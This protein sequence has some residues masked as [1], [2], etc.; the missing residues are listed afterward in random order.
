MIYG[1]K[2]GLRA[3]TA[4]DT[5]VLHAELYD[6]VPTQARSDT[7]PWRPL[8]ADSEHGP[9]AVRAPDATAE[10]FSVVELASGELAGE[11][12]LWSIDL[13]N[14]SA[15]LGL[16]LR[17]A[18]RGRGLGADVVQ[19][20]CRYGLTVRGLQRLQVETLTDN[21]AMIRA[22]EKAGFVR[23]GVRRRAGWVYGQWKDEVILGL[24][25]EDWT[26]V[27]EARPAA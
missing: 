4:A 1:Q 3:R 21:A 12:I 24:L 18:F 13:H 22:A 11:A 16:A 15:H 9:Y 6:H 14:R 25:A 19:A 2:T 7:R 26:E 23:E 17:P 27:P 8:P 5:P 10:P 20:L